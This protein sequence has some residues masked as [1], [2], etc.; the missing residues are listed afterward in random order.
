MIDEF[1]FIKSPILIDRIS[2]LKSELQIPKVEY[3]LK[4]FFA[5]KFEALRRFYCGPQYDFI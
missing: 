5:K 3:E 1:C 4:I 2:Q